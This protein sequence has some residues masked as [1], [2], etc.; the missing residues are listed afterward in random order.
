MYQALYRKYRSK[1]FDELVGQKQVTTPLKEQVKRGEVSHAYLFSGTRGTGKT[2]AAKIMSR[3]VNCLNPRD[4]NPCNE[5]ENCLGIL[6]DTMMD[7]V[8]MDAAS[9][10]GVD[11]IRELKDRVVYPPSVCRYKVYIIDEVHMLSKGAFNALL[12]V[13]EEPPAHLIFILATT[14]PEKIPQTIL[15][16]CQRFQFRRIGVKDMVSTMEGI[17]KKEGR[18]V[19]HRALVAIANHAGGAMR[20]ALSLLDQCLGFGEKVTY[21]EAMEA[22]G[23][24]NREFLGELTEGIL[25]RDSSRVLRNLDE[26][27]SLGKDM[28]QLTEDLARVLRNVMIVKETNLGEELIGEEDLSFYRNLAEMGDFSFLMEAWEG[29]SD[30][31]VRAKRSL[32][33]GGVLEMYLLRLTSASNASLEDRVRA[34]EEGSARFLLEKDPTKVSLKKE[35]PLS[36]RTSKGFSETPKGSMSSSPSREKEKENPQLEPKDLKEKS[37]SFH[38]G[39]LKTP[40]STLE[41]KATSD[42]IEGDCSEFSLS[43]VTSRWQEVLQEIKRRGRINVYGLLQDGK[44]VDVKGNQV[45]IGYESKFRFHIEA[46]STKT[47][48]SFLEEVLS[49]FF[50]RPLTVRVEALGDHRVAQK[51]VEEVVNLFG[52]FLTKE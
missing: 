39:P 7:V 38:R 15:S 21:E 48:L 42:I 23:M 19:D 35:P 49:D 16:R 47:N 40:E 34:L 10:N 43:E 11:D 4:G 14:E 33:P 12:K 30:A 20:D 44:P 28:V 46:L 9:N 17:L 6:R 1:T 51:A 25:T 26:L 41:E 36:R 45:V 32:N 52:E 29:L 18:E 3:A 31:L 13:L 2:S 22:L 5:C 24:T 50:G 37:R 27:Y 8:E